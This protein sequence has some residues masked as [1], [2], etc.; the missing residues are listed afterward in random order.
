LCSPP[1]VAEPDA[2]APIA[3]TDDLAGSLQ[4]LAAIRQAP[5][6]LRA[7]RDQ[8]HNQVQHSDNKP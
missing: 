4:G 6:R 5:V 1:M 3:V 7:I 8:F 2:A